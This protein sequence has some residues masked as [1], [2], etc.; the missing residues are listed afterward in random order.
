MEMGG[1]AISSLIHGGLILDRRGPQ[2]NQQGVVKFAKLNKLRQVFLKKQIDLPPIRPRWAGGDGFLYHRSAGRPRRSSPGAF[3][4]PIGRGL[5][6]IGQ[7]ILRQAELHPNAPA[8][9]ATRFKSLSYRDFRDY[10]VYVAA[11]LR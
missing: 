11:R 8:V 3:V 2:S 4:R 1:P 9:V 7:A 10:L 5:A 6:T